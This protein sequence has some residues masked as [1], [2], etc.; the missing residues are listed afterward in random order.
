VD[1]P[2]ATFLPVL[3][4]V[5]AGVATYCDAEEEDDPDER[6]RGQKGGNNGVAAAAASSSA[7]EGGNGA[8]PNHDWQSSGAINSL[9]M[10]KLLMGGVDIQA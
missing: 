3:R 9:Y 7:D 4:G 2:L 5:E 6:E 10:Q 8:Q 1:H